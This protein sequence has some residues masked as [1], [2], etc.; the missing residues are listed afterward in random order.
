MFKL[1][2]IFI[3]YLFFINTQ[4]INSQN[5]Y[6]SI[7]SGLTVALVNL[8]LCIALAVASGSTPSAGILSGIIGGIVSGLK[9]GSNYNIIGPT[10]ALSGFLAASVFRYGIHSLPYFALITGV[11]TLIIRNYGLARY[12]DLFPVSVNEGFT[13]GVAMIILINQINPALG[14]GKFK[15]ENFILTN[16]TNVEVITKEIVTENEDSLIHNLMNNLAHINQMNPS[17]FIIFAIFLGG[18]YY[19]IKTQPTIPWQAVAALVG[20]LIGSSGVT[21]V[22]TLY[23]KFGNVK[24]N[25]YDFSYL[26]LSP[27]T[28]LSPAV[29]VDAL[30]ITFIA[31]LET[32]ISAKIADGMTHTSFHKSNELRGLGLANI[33]SGVLGGMPITAALARTTLNIKSGANDKISSVINGVVLFFIAFMCIPLFKFL[34]ICV[35]AAQVSIVAIRMVNFAEIEHLYYKDKPN[36]I[37]LISTAAICILTDPTVGIIAGMLIFLMHFSENLITPWTEIIATH[38]AKVKANDKFAPNDSMYLTEEKKHHGVVSQE[39]YL[40]EN[41]NMFISDLPKGEGEYILYRIIGI[42]NFMNVKEHIDKLNKF[43]LTEN[44]ITIVISFRYLKFI[45]LEAM[46]AIKHLLDSVANERGTS[47]KLFNNKIVIMGLNKHNL[48]IFSDNKEWVMD[49]HKNNML[50]F[51]D[52]GHGTYFES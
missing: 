10:G 2:P 15:T 16:A 14:I 29:W 1:A 52:P 26:R 20:I 18:L 33:V 32:L 36:F 22:E 7:I 44:N 31:V 51:K 5:T 27:T 28:L 50:I 48:E 17:A 8:P 43:I 40:V 3:L 6:K 49:M 42:L 38:E 12:I 4:V 11:L 45:D 24:L 30:P 46:H 13:V 23:S 34:P 47:K 25:L 41:L 19:L 35:A 9:G 37:I 21:N 39:N